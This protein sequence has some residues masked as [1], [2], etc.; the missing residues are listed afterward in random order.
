[1]ELFFGSWLLQERTKKASAITVFFIEKFDFE[2]CK[3]N[4]NTFFF[5]G[6]TKI[7]YSSILIL[8]KCLSRNTLLLEVKSNSE[9]INRH[10]HR[11]TILR[12]HL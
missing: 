7:S 9:T 1:V 11:E 10:F 12:Y 4:K 2:I 6:A 8:E 3:P 5:K